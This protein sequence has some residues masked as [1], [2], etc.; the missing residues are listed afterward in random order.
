MKK[1]EREGWERAGDITLVVFK[2]VIKKKE[3]ERERI[4]DTS[5][6]EHKI[7]KHTEGKAQGNGD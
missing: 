4:K 7:K 6:K 2:S 1:R 5:I 3:R